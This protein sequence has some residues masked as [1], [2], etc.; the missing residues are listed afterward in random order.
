MDTGGSK[1]K[2]KDKL[3]LVAVA[4]FI[5]ALGAELTLY[6]FNLVIPGQ[7]VNMPRVTLEIFLNAG[8]AQSTLIQIMGVLWS[9]IIGGTYALIYLVALELTGWKNLWLKSL[10]VI[11]GIWLLG[12]GFVMNLLNI[13]AYTRVE[14]LSVVTFYVAH[15]AFAT[16]LSIL[17]GKLGQQSAAG[18]SDVEKK[19]ACKRINT[20]KNKHYLALKPAKKLAEPDKDRIFIKPVKH[21]KLKG[22]DN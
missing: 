7:N 9:T 19:A 21:R 10:I 1:F 15:L 18:E 3:I 22:R 11:N 17:F 20:N 5:A 2:I 14:P 16:Y 4:G 8:A 13:T 12:A 6:L